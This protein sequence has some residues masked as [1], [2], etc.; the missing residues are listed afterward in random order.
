MEIEGLQATI[1]K[2]KIDSDAAAKKAKLNET[3]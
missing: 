1:Q 2:M 3:R